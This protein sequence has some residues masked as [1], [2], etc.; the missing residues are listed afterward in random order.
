MGNHG[1]VALLLAWTH[2][3]VHKSTIGP[4]ID[5]SSPMPP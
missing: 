4:R 3:N 1:P 2:W 5:P